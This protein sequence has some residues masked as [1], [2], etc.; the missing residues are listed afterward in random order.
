MISAYPL[1]PELQST[2]VAALAREPV[3]L[4]FLTYQWQ[5]LWNTARDQGWQ[6]MFLHSDIA[7]GHC[8]AFETRSGVAR[9]S[10]GEEISDYMDIVGDP[11]TKAQ[12]WTEIGEYLKSHGITKLALRNIPADSPTIMVFGNDAVQEDTTPLFSLPKTWDAYLQQL[13]SERRHEIRRK[14]R[15][16]ERTFDDAHLH[17]TSDL[18][19]GVELLLRHMS[20]DIEK[21]NFLTP[22][23]EQFFRA[24][25]AA[26][27]NNTVIY[28]LEADGE[29]AASALGFTNGKTLYLYNAG[30]EIER[31]PGAGFYLAAS[32]IRLAIESGHTAYNFLQG[33]ERYKYDLGAHDFF[34]YKAAHTL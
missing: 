16:F 18:D 9:F 13:D 23:M 34:V 15:K 25:P 30:Y 29:A 3:W 27:P 10:G 14:L 7:R 17:T 32:S 11:N 6:P 5:E 33:N 20:I 28:K 24:I 22:A 1:G 8:A 4:P 2:W 26:F 19:T 12:A 21:R 31:Y